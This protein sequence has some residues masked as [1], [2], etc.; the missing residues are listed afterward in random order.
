VFVAKKSLSVL[1]NVSQL[2]PCDIF[3]KLTNPVPASA[4]FGKN[5]S[6][7]ALLNIGAGESYG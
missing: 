6:G 7:T 3:N 2:M 1:F 4:G 5:K